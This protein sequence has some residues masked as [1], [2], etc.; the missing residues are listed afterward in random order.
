MGYHASQ[1]IKR[2]RAMNLRSRVGIVPS[3]VCLAHHQVLPVIVDIGKSAMT[4]SSHETNIA[5]SWHCFC[6]TAQQG[7]YAFLL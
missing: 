5:T 6:A 1:R 2:F 3:P 4:S 7:R